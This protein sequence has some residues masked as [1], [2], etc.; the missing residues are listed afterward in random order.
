[1]EL[2]DSYAGTVTASILSRACK[3]ISLESTVHI[4][5]IGISLLSDWKLEMTSIEEEKVGISSIVA[6]MLLLDL[7]PFVDLSRP[8]ICKYRTLR[9]FHTMT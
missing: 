9:D 8:E 1:M 5:M 6:E 3:I 4:G 7:A 2:V